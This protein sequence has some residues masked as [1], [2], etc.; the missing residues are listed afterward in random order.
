MGI[1]KGELW[2]QR[3]FYIEILTKNLSKRPHRK[4]K[5][6]LK[7]HY[8]L[9]LI[10]TKNIFL[11]GKQFGLLKVTAFHVTEFFHFLKHRCQAPQFYLVRVHFLELSS[12]KYNAQV[13][14]D[15]E[16]F[17]SPPTNNCYFLKHLSI[18]SPKEHMFPRKGKKKKKNGLQN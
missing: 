17:F 5:K 8:K 1:C 3:R 4:K 18:T 11:L 7:Q 12:P 9:Y 10:V 13:K 6:I 14:N 2:R 15:F 16:A